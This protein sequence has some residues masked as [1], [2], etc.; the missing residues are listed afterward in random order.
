[1][2]DSDWWRCQSQIYSSTNPDLA[3]YSIVNPFWPNVVLKKGALCNIMRE[4]Q[5]QRKVRHPNILHVEGRVM[6][7]EVLSDGQ[8]AA[9]M[10]LPQEETSVETH[11]QTGYASASCFGQDP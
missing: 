8:P 9:Y 11:M 5:I 3:V 6:T 2:Q 4:A 10:A 1:M 7:T